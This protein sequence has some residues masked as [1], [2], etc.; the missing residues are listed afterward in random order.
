VTAPSGTEVP[1]ISETSSPS[2]IAT[3][4]VDAP[5]TS[6]SIS[7]D[8]DPSA[9]LM[10]VWPSTLTENPALLSITLGSGSEKR[11]SM[12]SSRKVQNES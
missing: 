2:A 11:S 6:E 3:T 12:P 10:P 9:Y 5:P 4:G 1:A 8:R 7:T